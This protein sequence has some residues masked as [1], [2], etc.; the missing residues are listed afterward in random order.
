MNWLILYLLGA[1]PVVTKNF[2]KEQSRN[3]FQKL[4]NHAY[5]L[6]YATSLRM[7]DLGYQNINQSRVDNITQFFAEK[8]IFDLK[9]ATSTNV[10]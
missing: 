7:S 4:D 1:S 6:P 10:R 2:L 8:Y 5:Y 3:G 9:Q